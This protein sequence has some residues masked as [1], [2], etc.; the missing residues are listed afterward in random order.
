[1]PRYDKKSRTSL[2]EAGSS[3]DLTK[4]FNSFEGNY[5]YG[6]SDKLI[7]WGNMC[8]PS[9]LEAT[10]YA[11]VAS[12][13]LVGYDMSVST[14]KHGLY[15]PST[16]ALINPSTS[17]FCGSKCT[18][19]L[20]GGSIG[21]TSPSSGYA[22][23]SGHYFRLQDH[24]DFTF[25]AGGVDK[26]FSISIWYKSTKANIGG[27]TAAGPISYII[28]KPFEFGLAVSGDRKLRFQMNDAA[29][30]ATINVTTAADP[31]STTDWNHIV[32][33][34][35]GS[36]TAAGM[37]IYVNG[38]NK[39]N[40]TG[41]AGSYS[42]MNNLPG[43]VY[44]GYGAVYGTSLPLGAS[45]DTVGSQALL[46]EPAVW[47]AELTK[48]DILAIRNASTSCATKDFKGSSGYTSISPRIKLRE[49][50]NHAGNYHTVF[51]TG[52]RDRKGNYSINF[53]DTS[54]I[55]FGEKIVDEFSNI[56]DSQLFNN[57]VD[58]TKWISSPG[59]EIRRESLSGYNGS[60]FEDGVLIF[61]G[62][63]QR[64]LRTK[65]KV[66]NAIIEFEV[67]LGPH[68]QSVLGLNLRTPVPTETLMLQMSTNGST[69]KTLKTLTPELD[70]V[71]FYDLAH[72]SASDTKNR[73]RKKIGVNFS[74]IAD[75][76]DAYY[77]RLI[78]SYSEYSSKAVWG[79]GRIS[80]E[81]IN[82]TVRYPLLTNHDSFHGRKIQDSFIV[83]PHTRSDIE[84]TSRSIRGISD[85]MLQFSPGESVTPFNETLAVEDMDPT[86]LFHAI[87]T[88]NSLMPGFSSKLSSKTKFTVDLSTSTSE[89]FGYTNSATRSP[90]GSNNHQQPLMVYYNHIKK[91][92]EP[93]AKGFQCGIGQVYAKDLLQSV[94]SSAV[95]YGPFGVVASSSYGGTGT[96][97]VEAGIIDTYCRTVSQF[98]FPWSG[99]YH[100][101]SSQII[102]AEDIGITKP[103]LLE[104]LVLDS[105]IVF[106]FAEDDGGTYDEVRGFALKYHKDAGTTFA[107][108][109]GAGNDVLNFVWDSHLRYYMPTFFILRQKPGEYNRGNKIRFSTT[110]STRSLR[111]EETVPGMFDLTGD[112]VKNT[113]VDTSRDVIADGQLGILLSGS[114]AATLDIDT[115]L[116]KGLERDALYRVSYD[117]PIA[118]SPTSLSGTFRVPFRPSVTQ[119]FRASTYL[120]TMQH[121]AS[122]PMHTASILMSNTQHGLQARGKY[123]RDM[124]T[125]R[126]LVNSLPSFSNR[127]MTTQLAARSGSVAFT[128]KRRLPTTPIKLNSPYIILPGDELIIGCQYPL[129]EDAPLFT[130]NVSNA[131]KNQMKFSGESK[132]HLYGSLISDNR[133]YHEF[134]NQNLNSDN[135]HEII[136]AEKPVDQFQVATI[137]E[138]TGT[139]ID[140][141]VFQREQWDHR[142]GTKLFPYAAAST[143]PVKRIGSGVQSATGRFW[144]LSGSYIGG[145][146]ANSNRLL[147]NRLGE[148]PQTQR[149]VQLKDQDRV[150]FDSAFR[151]GYYF[152]GGKQLD[153]HAIHRIGGAPTYNSSSILGYSTYGTMQTYMSSAYFG[154]HGAPY[155]SSNEKERFGVKSKSP[156]YY[157]NYKHFGH[158]SDMSQQARDGKLYFLSYLFVPDFQNPDPEDDSKVDEILPPVEVQ[159]VTG[160]LTGD[161]AVQAYHLITSDTKIQYLKYRNVVEL[162]KLSHFNV[163]QHAT[164]SYPYDDIQK[165]KG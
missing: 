143:D 117:G 76:G 30:S 165:S 123:F 54:T 149:F 88:E 119:N 85:T 16:M 134:S 148:R 116:E 43:H 11:S 9:P 39:V 83:T 55:S 97:T 150:F 120:G 44:F 126:R 25:N 52:D 68:N 49:L 86:N 144:D 10:Y 113:Y 63:G 23:T 80:I 131:Y 32:L 15:S 21:L 8:N 7:F 130:T 142:T 2:P 127:A 164:S 163:S 103:F 53:D 35:D 72:G 122:D 20:A 33:T 115:I 26:P 106:E 92:W 118:K 157:F 24:N 156:T 46:Y 62:A 133:E 109:G 4:D 161:S 128:E 90:E 42:G 95:G 48:E 41:G 40:T 29:S 139:Y 125:S 154:S 82:E 3:Y 110:G 28:N 65:N 56:K 145:V 89:Y 124:E 12:S 50:D 137:Q 69:W 91:A 51:R 70:L 100:A 6:K 132:I 18:F 14:T 141:W 19:G 129:M 38:E 151:P 37:K 45:L 111:Y 102:K 112:G 60:T 77:I 75:P 159:F 108:G 67:V 96:D 71:K 101:S 162:N 107:P 59:L 114:S 27:T 61:K 5:R 140:D 34:Y 155:W 36:E 47:N 93:I 121:N 99:R 94:T 84:A 152:K 136:G 104:K 66:R 160:K 78:Q 158:L 13:A 57:N 147:T 64:Y 98:N 1:M 31:M 146:L 153:E 87:G 17:D 135:L 74:S 73:Y 58:T 105:G 138:L 79:I 22:W 81:S